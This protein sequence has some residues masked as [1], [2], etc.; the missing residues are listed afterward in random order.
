MRLRVINRCAHTPSEAPQPRLPGCLSLCRCRAVG[1]TH[2]ATCQH[3]RPSVVSRS[4]L[5]Q[6]CRCLLLFERRSA[7]SPLHDE[8]AR[9]DRDSRCAARVCRCIVEVKGL[10]FKTSQNGEDVET[11]SLFMAQVGVSTEHLRRPTAGPW[12]PRMLHSRGHTR[13][14][15]VWLRAI[16]IDQCPP[17]ITQELCNGGSLRDKVLAQMGSW[18]KVCCTEPRRGNV[19][20]PALSRAS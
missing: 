3:C 14:Y 8:E 4:A 19:V 1:C 11:K 18:H 10:G 13:F 15:M 20:V 16:T 6:H 5:C 7:R 9:P 12:L 2:F 17:I